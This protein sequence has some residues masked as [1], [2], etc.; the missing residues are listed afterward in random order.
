MSTIK[1]EDIEPNIYERLVNHFG[2]QIEAGKAI[3]VAQCTIS[4][5]LNN[6]WGMSEKTAIKTQK[7]TNGL[8]KAVDFCPSLRDLDNTDDLKK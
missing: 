1:N 4:G 8:F 3:G 7:A 6:K 5:Y 2:G